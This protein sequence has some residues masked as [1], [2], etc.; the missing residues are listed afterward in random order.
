MHN[1]KRHTVFP[2]ILQKKVDSNSDST[3]IKLKDKHNFTDFDISNDD[4]IDSKM[5]S[6]DNKIRSKKNK[7]VMLFP[8]S[9]KQRKSTKEDHR[10]SFR[11]NKSKFSVSKNHLKSVKEKRNTEHKPDKSKK[12]RSVCINRNDEQVTSGDEVHNINDSFISTEFD[13]RKLFKRTSAALDVNISKTSQSNN[14]KRSKKVESQSKSKSKSKRSN[15]SFKSSRSN[16]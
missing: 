9:N 16:R 7:S 5:D 12:I 1:Q 13:A 11:S 3:D 2:K 14:S 15:K 4:K 10:V 8:L 6:I